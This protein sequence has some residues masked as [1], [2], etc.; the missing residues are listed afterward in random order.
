MATI[1]EYFDTD[2]RGLTYHVDGEIR[3]SRSEVVAR[4]TAKQVLDLDANARYLYYFIADGGDLSA[5]I[6]G[7]IRSP[8]VAAG[9][10]EAQDMMDVQ[11]GQDGYSEMESTRTLVFT[12]RVHIYVDAELTPD[13]R[14]AIVTD[15]LGLGLHIAVKDREYARVR[16]AAEKPLAFISHD[17]RDKDAF[18][19]EL[20]HQLATNMCPVWYDEFS[21]KVGDSLRASIDR[22][23]KETSKCIVI[24][25]P[26]FFSNEGWG[27]AEFDAVFTREI[28]EKKNV[29]LPVWLGVDAA[30]VY[31]FNARLLDKVGLPATLGVAEVA[32]RLAQAIKTTD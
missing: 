31:D 21:L 3:N 25:S 17:T 23:L 12:K 32:R 29:I 19:R 16:S 7:I 13:I 15:G 24:L 10:I 4:V 14:K 26:N 30:S 20:A 8:N 27:K 11:Q 22:G 28:F 18:V 2:P 1:R 9:R 6:G 5:A